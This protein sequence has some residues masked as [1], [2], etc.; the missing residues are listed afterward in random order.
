[1]SEQTYQ[2]LKW[3]LI[4]G[5]YLPG[6]KISIRRQAEEMG[7]GMMPVREALKRLASEQALI[8]SAS[9]SFQVA[10]L[11]PE[12]ITN[13]LF[14]RSALE[15]IATEQAVP[16]ITGSTLARIRELAI[17]MDEQI[18]RSDIRAYLASNYSFHF[19]IYTAS[20]NPEL[21]DLIE[22]LW[23]RTGPFVA[24]VSRS[25]EISGEWRENHL[26]IVDAIRARDAGHARRL[27]ETDIHWG[28]TV[29]REM[30]AKR[31]KL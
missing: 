27:I 21:A 17:K 20:A 10:E 1:M 9:R 22:G 31:D 16:R 7:V 14:I 26:K 19:L 18:E 28:I 30:G 8:S 29:Y 13:L 2:D 3:G 23:A 11:D 12:R 6:T 25:V 15:G 4:M 5:D 24:A